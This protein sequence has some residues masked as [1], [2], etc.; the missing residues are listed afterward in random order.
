MTQCE[1]MQSTHSSLSCTGHALLQAQQ[2]VT[3]YINILSI[4]IC[5][6]FMISISNASIDAYLMVTEARLRASDDVGAVSAATEAPSAPG[7][8]TKHGEC[9]VRP[10]LI[11][12]I[13]PLATLTTQMP[14]WFGA[15]VTA[16]ETPKGGLG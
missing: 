1:N 13:A 16:A 9:E 5:S 6:I 10:K 4:F 11:I 7:I 14:P 12:G 8:L 2:S 3:F 15:K